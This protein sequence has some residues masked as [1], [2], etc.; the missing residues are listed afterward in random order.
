[1]TGAN[2]RT[3]LEPLA[4]RAAFASVPA[5]VVAVCS[6]V[7]GE[8][9]GMAVS[10]FVPVSLD[11]PLVS[12]CVQHTSTTWP[13]LRTAGRIG[14]SV[15][16][17]D[18]SEAVRTLAAKEGDRFAGLTTRTVHGD[19]VHIHGSTLQLTTSIEN[20]VDAGDHQIIV[21]RVH[22]AHVYDSVEPVVFHGSVVRTLMPPQH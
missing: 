6:E 4:L 10:S 21:L 17:T 11:P 22:E 14:I 2:T 15:L 9:V 1:M 18:H 16:G 7:D 5:G 12:F 20:A 8:R 13:R 19:A 3:D